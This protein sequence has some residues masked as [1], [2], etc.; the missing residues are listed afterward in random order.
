M[1]VNNLTI[2]IR[3]NTFGFKAIF[4]SIKVI[5]KKHFFVR[6][7]LRFQC[8][9]LKLVFWL[10]FDNLLNLR[11]THRTF[12]WFFGNCLKSFAYMLDYFFVSKNGR[13]WFDSFKKFWL[14]FGS[15]WGH[16]SIGNWIWS[17]S[18]PTSPEIVADCSKLL[19]LLP[20]AGVP[21]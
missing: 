3:A 16:W 11:M 21:K 18:V 7:I 10:N 8:P 9:F 4:F 13:F 2:A 15:K 5:K 12:L 20:S 14:C 1:R 6:V 17:K 19:S